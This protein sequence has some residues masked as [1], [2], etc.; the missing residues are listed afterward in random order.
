MFTQYDAHWRTLYMWKLYKIIQLK[1]RL[2]RQPHT[3]MYIKITAAVGLFVHKLKLTIDVNK[4]FQILLKC[5]KQAFKM[6][7][8]G[9]VSKKGGGKGGNPFDRLVFIL[10]WE[11]R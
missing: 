9:R 10:L 4:T 7:L 2:L 5:W 3:N 11:I 6:S 1:L 8:K